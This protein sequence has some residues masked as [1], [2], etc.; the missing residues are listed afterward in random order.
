MKERRSFK[1]NLK[2]RE[3]GKSGNR[4]RSG[5]A[6]RLEAGSSLHQCKKP[7]CDRRGS[8]VSEI[9]EFSFNLREI[10]I[11]CVMV[12]KKVFPQT[13]SPSIAAIT[14]APPNLIKEKVTRIPCVG[15]NSKQQAKRNKAYV[16]HFHSRDSQKGQ[17]GKTSQNPPYLSMQYIFV[18]R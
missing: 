7:G 12:R 9:A 14:R 2:I 18:S 6:R 5:G 15:L 3:S 8:A 16:P 13:G 4:R 17:T 10:L 11:V 1:H